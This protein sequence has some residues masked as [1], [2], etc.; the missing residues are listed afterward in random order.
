M[1]VIIVG[2]G[3]IG[4]S[5]AWYASK[6][7]FEVTVLDSGD[8]MVN[9]S[10]GNAGYISPSHFIPLASPGIVAQGLRWML[11]PTSPFYIRLKADAALAR[12]CWSFYRKANAKDVARN[13]PHLNQLLGLSRRLVEDL[14]QQ[15]PVSV[16]LQ[17][18]GC[19]MLYKKESTGR[20]EAELAHEARAL[21]WSAEV[22]TAAEVQAMEP[23]VR[24]D[25]LGGVYFPQD[26]HLHPGSL[27]RA[28]RQDLVAGGVTFL[29]S[30]EVTGF[31]VSG[32]RVEAVKT[33]ESRLTCDAVVLATGS[34]LAQL[35]AGLGLSLLV[36][37]GKGY[38]MTFGDQKRSLQHPAILVDDR[39]A[40]TPLGTDLRVGGTMELGNAD[41]TINM[42]RVRPIVEAA[43]TYYPDLQL[44]VP[45]PEQVWYGL[46]PCTPDGLPYLGKVP[47]LR[48]AVVAGGHAM[49][50]ISMAAGTG[51]LVS[52]MLAGEKTEIPVEGFRVDR[53]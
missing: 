37:P 20:H 51:L 31:D 12:W 1:K 34:Q 26:A 19:L 53:F 43:N 50:G 44:L 11:S 45:K 9:C 6:K 13:A 30:N 40:M 46:R 3:V 36:Q 24:V 25:V 21:G 22:L 17:T 2:G 35:A 27:M 39:V 16:G 7:G 18:K 49:I 41:G 14:A 23:D 48:N 15:L 8:G 42:R 5:C 47:H 32:D 52:Q 29:S 10:W 28:L 38:S 33:R 4:L